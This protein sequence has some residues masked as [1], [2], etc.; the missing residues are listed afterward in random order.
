[1]FEAFIFLV[2][3]WILYGVV[4]G[5]ILRFRNGWFV[6][7]DGGGDTG[8]STGSGQGWTGDTSYS[9]GGSDGGGGGD[10]GGD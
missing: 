7:G 9:D 3:A 5:L 2:T 1:M 8:S 6:R 10:G 4:R